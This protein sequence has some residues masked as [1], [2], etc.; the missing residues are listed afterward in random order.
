M[1]A[2]MG[3]RATIALPLLSLLIGLLRCRGRCSNFH[4]FSPDELIFMQAFTARRA[5]VTAAEQAQE[6]H[7][8]EVARQRE[9]E[10]ML[11]QIARTDRALDDCC[12]PIKAVIDALAIARANFVGAAVF[13]LEATAPELVAGMLQTCAGLYTVT[14]TQ[15]VSKTSGA[16]HWDATTRP[17]GLTPAFGTNNASYGSPASL[18]IYL[19]DLYTAR[20][21]RVPCPSLFYIFEE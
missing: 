1:D 8:R 10:Q 11:A 9:H 16:V 6:S 5:E 2:W 3:G 17:S 18:A 20:S 12:R 4:Q 7:L 19:T 14:S 13:E 21:Q 15:M